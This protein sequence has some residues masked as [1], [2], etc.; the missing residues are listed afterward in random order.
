MQESFYIFS[1][2]EIMRKDNTIR[3]CTEDGIKKDIPIEKV[4]DI[5]IFGQVSL[6]SA[7]LNILYKNKIVLHFYN[8]YE[9]YI[10]SFHPKEEHISGSLLVSQ[11]G[12]Y[13]DYTKRCE[14]ARKFVR[15]AGENILRN[16][17]YYNN[18]GREFDKAIDEI[19]ALLST[20]ERYDDIQAI[21][22][23]EG[24]IRKIYYG[25][26]ND[27]IN[28]DINFEKRIKRPPD[29]MVNSLISFLNSMLYSKTVSEIYK[30]QLNPSI[31]YLHEP[32]V[33]RF[34]LSLDVTEI[35]KPLIVD[36]LIFSLLNKGEIGE[37]DFYSDTN[38]IRLKDSALKLIVQKF[39]ER[40]KTTIMHRSLKRDVSYR[41]LI[42]LE[43]YKL[44]KHFIGD[45]EYEP[46]KIWW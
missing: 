20:L 31:S 25:L 8:Y 40:L 3:L 34:S 26:W 41:Y 2:G 12:F 11:V 39:D 24:N 27:I 7:L 35:F 29:N 23:I 19:E 1:N 30:T 43:L 6:N 46:F 18:R 15:G 5:H 22:G 16:I 13:M 17:R 21:M 36:R 44:I 9:H 37:S 33:K 28:Q 10:G 45:K 42:R 32:F 38:G 14:L 4:Y